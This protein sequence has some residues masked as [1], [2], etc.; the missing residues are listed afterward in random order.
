MSAVRTPVSWWRVRWRD[1]AG[2][3]TLDVGPYQSKKVAERVAHERRDP[4]SRCFGFAY[5]VDPPPPP[6]AELY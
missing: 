1:R 3:I 5:Q 6:I 2:E 4:S